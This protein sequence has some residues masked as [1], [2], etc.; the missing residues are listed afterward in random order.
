M[1][2]RLFFLIALFGIGAWLAPQ[3]SFARIHFL[4]IP[5]TGGTTMHTLLEKRFAPE[6]FYPLHGVLDMPT[7]MLFN[8]GQDVIDACNACPPIREK[9]S[10]GHFPFWFLR[11]KDP[12]FDSSFCF[13]ILRDPV[14]RVISNYF[15]RLANGR[16]IDSPLGIVQNY[17]C[18]MCAS[19]NTLEG[20]ELLQDSMR[21]LRRM[22]QII[23]LDDYE[24]GV[25]RLFKKLGLKH[26]K[27]IPFL[28]KTARSPID[29]EM[30]QKIREKNDLDI[31][32][33]EYA[34]TFLKDY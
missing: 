24:N 17:M 2:A 28:N 31:R 12:E 10:W 6:D 13:T 33:Y 14:E 5:K 3:R 27:Q 19:N 21:N 4:H 8:N 11:D 34:K 32:L 9:I 22:N 15:F 1:S 25:D 30:I 7:R 20:E 18:K 29:A 23:F 16:D 26:R